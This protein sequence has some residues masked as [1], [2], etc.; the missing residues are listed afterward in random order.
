VEILGPA[1]PKSAGLVTLAALNP[2]L[3][4]DRRTR[5]QAVGAA[6]RNLKWIFKY[7]K[8]RLK[9]PLLSQSY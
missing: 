3:L 9:M 4:N 6:I 1:N 2:M 7:G 5:P 8:Q